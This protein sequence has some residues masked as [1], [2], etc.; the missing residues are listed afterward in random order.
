MKTTKKALSIVLAGL[1]TVSG[2]SVISV[3]AAETSKPTLAFKT[4]NALYAHAVSGSEDSDAWVAWQCE[5]DD[6]LNE[7]NTNQKYFFLPSSVSSTSV[8]LYNAYSSSVTVNNVTIPA[9]ESKVVSYTVDKAGNVNAGGKTYSLTFLK[10]SAESAIYVNNSDADGNGKELISYLN[11]DKSNSASATGAI[12]DKDG[13]INNTAIKKIKGRGNSTWGK[14]KKPY[15]ITYTD[16]VSIAGMSKGKKFSLLA[17]YQDD[18]LS[19]NRFL[20][21]LADAVGTPYASDLRYVD[22]YADGY[23]WG[24]YQMT[25]KI[26]VGKNALISDIDDTAY[27]DADGNVNKDFPFLCE[28]DSGAT[29]GEDYY[30]SCDDGI[31]VTIKAPEL[32]EGD[33]GYN[34]VKNYVRDKYNA[35]HRAAKNA[36]SDLSQYADVDSCAKLWLI[37]ELGKNWD[38]GV[39]SAYFVYKQD[40]NGNYKFFASPVWDYDNA[41]GNANGVEWELDNMGVKDYTKYSGWWCRFKGRQKRSQDSN[42][43]INNIS[44][45]TQVNKA[46]VNI[47]FEQFVPAINYFAGKTTSYSGSNEIYT[48]TQYYNALKGSAEMNYKSGWLL[49]TG[50]WIA[51]HTSL[52]KADFD[53]ATGTY[54]VSSTKTSYNQNDFTDMFNYTAD[55]M[56]SRAAWISSK[57]FSEYTPSVVAGDVD[58]DGTVTVMDAT[59]VQKYI[60]N[61]ESLTDAQLKTADVNGDGQVTVVDAT[62]IQKLVVNLS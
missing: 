38:S 37:N 25:E 11:E 6:E 50:S 53:M 3:S 31:K 59:L 33:K 18:S 22:F 45:N 28:V 46:A 55:W 5:H 49:K 26:E 39:S 51:D 57:W 54:T 7:V 62:A 48:K 23:Y 41:L 24:S 1:M 52:S 44:R 58:G 8:E 40:A 35:F 56:T 32:S 60:V 43:I 42:N 13:T 47:W 15:N 12:V 14:S 61:L 16:K 30:V 29:D 2:M 4:Q 19:R 34:E 10:S 21:D 20:Y 36:D 9:G 27:L 17:N